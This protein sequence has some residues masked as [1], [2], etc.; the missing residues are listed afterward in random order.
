MRP[1]VISAALL[2]FCACAHEA[3]PPLRLLGDWYEVR[4]G[5]T[6]DSVAQKH[7]VDP[8]LLAELNELPAGP[9][10]NRS[11]IFIPGRT[12]A[13]PGTGS[14]SADTAT[15]ATGQP[16]SDRPAAIVGSCNPAA[17][18]CLVW[19]ADGPVIRGFGSDSRSHHDGIDIGAKEGSEVRAAAAGTVIYSGD[20]IKGYGNLIL[21]RH[22]D[23]VISV[24]AHNAA[25]AAGEG[26]AVKAGDVIAT[27]GKTGA[28]DAP[29]L[30]FEVRRDEQPTDP[31]PLLRRK[32]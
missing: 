28:A 25:N 8:A 9:I 2:F 17:D 13:P 22:A 14:T 11:E 7:G 1:F 12:G 26:S 24:Y 4:D 20:A 15:E 29:H 3:V 19:P 21:I 5:D 30:H 16:L 10:L 31:I 6:V 23:G 32:E 18:I 27:V